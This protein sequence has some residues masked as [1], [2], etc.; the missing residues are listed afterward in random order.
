MSRES[1]RK[2]KEK[3][4]DEKRTGTTDPGD[5]RLAEWIARQWRRDEQPTRLEAYRMEK[6]KGMFCREGVAAYSRTFKGTDKVDINIAAK[7]SGEILGDCQAHCDGHPSQRPGPFTY[8]VFVSD[9]GRSVNA[10]NEFAERPIILY[11]QRLIHQPTEA[12]A[13]RAAGGGD[14]DDEDGEHGSAN[15]ALRKTLKVMSDREEWRVGTDNTVVGEVLGMATSQWREIHKAYMELTKEHVALLH[16]TRELDIMDKDHEPERVR[17]MAMATLAKEGVG[18]LGEGVKVIKYL[19]MGSKGGEGKMLPANGGPA[20]PI[21]KL[22]AIVSEFISDCE[23]QQID[24][25]LFGRAEN[26]ELVTPGIFTRDQGRIL[27][28]VKDGELPDSE[29][30]KLLPDSK[31]PLAITGEQ[32]NLAEPVLT[33][34]GLGDVIKIVFGFCIK[35]RT[36]RAGAAAAQAKAPTAPQEN[37]P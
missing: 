23:K 16:R 12:T 35:A 31:S 33:K 30:E 20:R 37:A 27:V 10:R 17:A 29:L 9:A 25:T 32:Y 26:G 28:L 2:K 24:E 8:T 36:A 11:P 7:I 18:A 4:Q 22:Q 5:R 1:D 6:V 21:T 3:E 15:A 14:E 34:A 13:A 19:I